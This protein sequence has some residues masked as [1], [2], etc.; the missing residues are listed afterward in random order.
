MFVSSLYCHHISV[1]FLQTY[2]YMTC[3]Q[4]Q[5]GNKI[6]KIEFW[7]NRTKLDVGN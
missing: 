6:I 2:V 4:D 1:A 7:L 5:G 3:R